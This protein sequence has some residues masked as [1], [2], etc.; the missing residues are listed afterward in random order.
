[1]MY[2][3]D[4]SPPGA[5]KPDTETSSP[6]SATKVAKRN[7]LP[8]F[9]VHPAGS[10]QVGSPCESN[11]DCASSMC[12]PV[13]DDDVS[14]TVGQLI[15]HRSWGATHYTVS[16]AT[17]PTF[18]DPIWS[19]ELDTTRAPIRSAELPECSD[20]WWTVSA[21]NPH[22]DTIGPVRPFRT[23]PLGELNGDGVVDAED[24][25]RWWGARHRDSLIGDLDRDGDIDATDLAI[26][27]ANFGSCDD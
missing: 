24:E 10:D 12:V 3:G 4:A 17:D 25:A 5:G 7:W 11:L 16:L 26:L 2:W 6:P 8:A 9:S 14:P 1:M 20:F 22:G 27:R 19:L 13:T 21:H 18:A 23:G 15:W